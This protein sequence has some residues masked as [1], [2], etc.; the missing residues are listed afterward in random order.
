LTR[1]AAL[2]L[3]AAIVLGGCGGSGNGEQRKLAAPFAYDK[4]R[5]FQ[6]QSEPTTLGGGRV[7]VRDV[8]FTGPA[9]SRLHGYLVAPSDSGR[10]PAVFYAHGAGGDRQELL[11]QAVAMARRGAVTLTLTMRYSP[12]RPT[13]VPPGLQGVRVNAKVDLDAVREV[14]RAVDFLASLPS[15]DEDRFGFVGWSAGARTGAI[16]AGVDHRIKAFDLLAGGALPMS[17]YIAQAPKAWQAELEPLFAKIDPLRYVAHAAPSALLFQDGTLDEV[18][19]KE[20]L[21]TLAREGSEPKELRW[22]RSGHTPTKQGWRDSRE[23]LA[24]QLELG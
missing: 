24:D 2:V 19:S 20:E 22:Y 13:L 5:P 15:V 1:G 23:W 7:E 10:H 4:S 12:T 8:S 3:A 16:V 18:F 6:L 14:L 9:G 17:T 11:Q 21:T